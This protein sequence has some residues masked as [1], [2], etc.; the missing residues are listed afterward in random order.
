[1][2]R[3]KSWRESFQW[4]APLGDRARGTP[5]KRALAA[6]HIGTVRTVPFRPRPSRGK[7]PE[8][9]PRLALDRWGDHGTQER[10]LTPTPHRSRNRRF[11]D[12]GTRTQRDRTAR[13]YGGVGLRL[14]RCYR[15]GSGDKARTRLSEL[16]GQP[17]RDSAI[18]M[19]IA[20]TARTRFAASP[21]QPPR[22]PFRTER[23]P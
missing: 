9:R 22:K 17:V 20:S 19:P 4:Y 3:S 5:R 6:G 14:H 21:T 7:T 16:G 2:L 15:T 13:P 12:G 1:M 10:C 11:S 8:P 18:G 23:R